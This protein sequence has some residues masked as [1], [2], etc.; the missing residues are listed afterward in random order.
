MHRRLS[1]WVLA[2]L[3]VIGQAALL[4]HQSDIDAHGPDGS[5]SICLLVHGLDHAVPNQFALHL[6]EPQQ[7]LSI[8][9]QPSAWV[10][11]TIAFYWTR[12]PPLYTHHS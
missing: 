10:R 3:L 8:V 7:A 6:D 2:A 1:H 11:H 4:V 5:C 12:A 9:A